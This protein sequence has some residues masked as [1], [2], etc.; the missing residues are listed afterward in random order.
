[1]MGV[2]RRSGK[3]KPVI[4]K[5]LVELD[6]GMFQAYKAVRDKWAYLDCYVSPGPIQFKG[7]ASD[8]L[9]FMVLP[10]DV[11]KLVEETDKVEALE[12][13]GKRFA[14]DITL[15][16]EL[17]QARVLDV[18]TIPTYLDKGTFTVAASKKYS[19]PTQQINRRLNLSFPI[20][21]DQDTANYFV[22]IQDIEHTNTKYRQ[23]D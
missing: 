7:P 22:E 13:S 15:L 17:S 6:G 3:D 1:M 16:S 9:N 8:E 12:K 18:P 23:H 10:P 5:A 19:A 21:K 4:S 20:L 14:R 11:A 2:E